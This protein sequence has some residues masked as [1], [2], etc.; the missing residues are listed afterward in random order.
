MDVRDNKTFMV[1]W[2]VLVIPSHCRPEVG[3]NL[4]NIDV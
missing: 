1:D 2:L 4:G 3:V